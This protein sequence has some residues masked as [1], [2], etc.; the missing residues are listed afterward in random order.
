MNDALK[1]QLV[2]VGGAMVSYIPRYRLRHNTID[3]ARAAARKVWGTMQARNLPT[4]CHPAIV[5]GPGCG[6]DGKVVN[7]W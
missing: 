1:F 2:F 6:K 3:G 4:A 5:Y 7:P